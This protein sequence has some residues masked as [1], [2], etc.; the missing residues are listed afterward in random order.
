MPTGAESPLERAAF[1]TVAVLTLGSAALG[2]G[3]AAYFGNGFEA[4]LA[5]DA[6]RAPNHTV[7][8]LAVIGH[9]HIMLAL[10]AVAIMLVV[11][12]LRGLQGGAAPRGYAHRHRGQHYHG[13][14]LLGGD[15]VGGG[16]HCHLR[17]RAPGVA[18]GIAAGHIRVEGGPVMVVA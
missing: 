6:I 7:A 5:E 14:G 18:G 9:L 8:Q 16:S 4:F 1:F 3:A 11:G 2:A 13:P 17:G 15:G 10:I 12:A